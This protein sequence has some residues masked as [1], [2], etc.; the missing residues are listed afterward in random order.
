M[1]A[2]YLPFEDDTMTGLFNKIEKGDFEMPDFFSPDV[3]SMIF[4]ILC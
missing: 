1:L 3:K 2:G 4:K